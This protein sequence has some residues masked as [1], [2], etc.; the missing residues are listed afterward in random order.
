MRIWPILLIAF[1]GFQSTVLAGAVDGDPENPCKGAPS[2]EYR[3]C[4]LK[5]RKTPTRT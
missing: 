2:E 4:I 5:V 3:P 1:V